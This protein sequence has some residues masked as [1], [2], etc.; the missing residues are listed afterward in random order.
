MVSTEQRLEM[1]ERHDADLL[2]SSAMVDAACTRL[3]AAG[4]IPAAAPEHVREMVHE[5]LR[6]ALSAPVFPP[7]ELLKRGGDLIDSY[8]YDNGGP[9]TGGEYLFR[10]ALLASPVAPKSR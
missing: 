7:Q 9:I 3:A 1:T 10:E 2:I 4:L 6:A 8:M 5:A